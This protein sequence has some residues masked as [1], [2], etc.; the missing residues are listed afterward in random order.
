MLKIKRRQTASQT[1]RHTYRQTYRRTDRQTDAH[2]QLYR[3]SHS[4]RRHFLIAVFPVAERQHTVARRDTCPSDF[5]TYTA[6]QPRGGRGGCTGIWKKEWRQRCSAEQRQR[7]QQLRLK[8]T[9]MLKLMK[10][11]VKTKTEK[12]TLV[13]VESH[14]LSLLVCSLLH[15][16]YLHSLSS[17]LCSCAAICQGP[18]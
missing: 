18:S 16:T 15:G 13:R 6:R 10:M 2:Y 14:S 9:K 12:L 5:H 11:T 1:Y 3:L 7:W 17:S 8:K 4:S